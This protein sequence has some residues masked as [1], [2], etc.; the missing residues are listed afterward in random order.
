VTPAGDASNRGPVDLVQD[1]ESYPQPEVA[2]H[3]V[4]AAVEVGHRDD[5]IGVSDAGPTGA[6]SD[7]VEAEVEQVIGRRGPGR[8]LKC[9]ERGRNKRR[10][11]I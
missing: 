3:A 11:Q 8:G 5:I 2:G 1:R 6:G 10:I 7:G 9:D 4:Q